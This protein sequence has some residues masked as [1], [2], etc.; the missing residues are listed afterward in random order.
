MLIMDRVVLMLS[1][2]LVNIS[3]F[4][5]RSKNP[6]SGSLTERGISVPKSFS[7]D[8]TPGVD[9]A[10]GTI[11]SLEGRELNFPNSRAHAEASTSSVADCPSAACHTSESERS[12]QHSAPILTSMGMPNSRNTV[13][14]S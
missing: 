5:P 10:M 6:R 4:T 12:R 3:E 2:M 8:C 14:P 1:A 11:E 9:Y 13:N 7:I